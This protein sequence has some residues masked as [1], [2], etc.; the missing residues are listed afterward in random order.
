MAVYDK[1][2]S[3]GG[4]EH[5]ENLAG[6]NIE[7]HGANADKVLDFLQRYVFEADQARETAIKEVRAELQ[8]VHGDIRIMADALRTVRDRADDLVDAAATDA[9]ERTVRQAMADAR[10]HLLVRWLVVLALAVAGIFG[11]EV[12]LIVDRGATAGLLRASYELG[13]GWRR[14]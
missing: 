7:H 3:Q 12:W 4:D 10:W 6:G 2:S 8:R 11:V 13:L 9:A 14:P 5:I 1:G